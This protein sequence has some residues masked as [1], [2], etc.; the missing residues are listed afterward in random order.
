MSDLILDKIDE[1]V[2]DAEGKLLLEFT[3]I[4]QALSV[5][6]HTPLEQAIHDTVDDTVN[7]TLA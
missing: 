1:A 7:P 5:E 2:E 4:C 3:R 6:P